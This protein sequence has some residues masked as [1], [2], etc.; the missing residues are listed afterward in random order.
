MVQGDFSE[1]LFITSCTRQIV[2]KVSPGCQQGKVRLY[3]FNSNDMEKFVQTFMCLRKFGCE[4][5]KDKER[6]YLGVDGFLE[7]S[8]GNDSH[9]CFCELVNVKCYT[10]NNSPPLFSA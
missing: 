3:F 8:L 5:E 6:D 1:M 2:H 4:R 7:L 10:V 9:L